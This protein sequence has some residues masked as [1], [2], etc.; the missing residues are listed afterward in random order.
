MTASVPPQRLALDPSGLV[1]GRSVRAQSWR[2][3]AHNLN[4]VLGHGAHIVPCYTP[5]NTSGL[6]S[7]SASTT[8]TFRYY[9]KPRYQATQRLWLFSGETTTYPS[10]VELTGTTGPVSVIASPNRLAVSP[11]IFVDDVTQSQTGGEWTLDVQPL[12]VAVTPYLLGCVDVPRLALSTSGNDQGTDL[13][14]LLPGRPVDITAAQ[15]I[16]DA[17]GSIIYCG[18]RASYLQWSVPDTTAFARSGT[19]TAYGSNYVLGS[20]AAADAPVLARLKFVGG[21]T[22]TVSARIYCWSTGGST[23]HAR[24]VRAATGATSSEVTVTSG[25][26]A[27]SDEMTISCDATNLAVSDGRRSSRWDGIDVEIYTSSG[28]WYCSS[29][30]AWED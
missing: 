28:T 20:T 8:Y 16:V 3:L 10:R 17:T 29:L 24:L 6:I 15:N 30:S 25:T 19:A 18:R 11:Q 26:G 27:W 21:T 7:L 12:D 2:T 1:A 9:T 14:R 13:A 4:W 23:I 5:A 22:G